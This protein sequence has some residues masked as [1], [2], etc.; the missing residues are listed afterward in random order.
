MAKQSQPSVQQLNAT[1][2]AYKLR[3][4]FKNDDEFAK[5]LKLSKVTTYTRLKKSNWTNPEIIWIEYLFNPEFLLLVDGL[6]II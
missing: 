5:K 1:E 4:E 6:N 3:H 2:K